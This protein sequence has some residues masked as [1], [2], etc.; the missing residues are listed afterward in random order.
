MS[1]HTSSHIPHRADDTY[2]PIYL[3]VRFTVIPIIEGGRVG[4]KNL[5]QFILPDASLEVPGEKRQSDG[6][7]LT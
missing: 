4:S 3:Y 1:R 2:I 6:V 7:S 5:F